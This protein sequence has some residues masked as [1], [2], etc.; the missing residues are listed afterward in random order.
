MEKSLFVAKRV[1]VRLGVA[2][3]FC[4]TWYFAGGQ[5][6]PPAVP[7]VFI[8][9]LFLAAA[10]FSYLRHDG[11]L[12]LNRRNTP[13]PRSDRMESAFRGAFK[14]QPHEERLLDTTPNTAPA[15]MRLAVLSNVLAGVLSI[16]LS[17]LL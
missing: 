13:N 15:D 12:F 10:W 8:G 1:A 6:E 3:V 11:L 2:A 9:A 14:P 16:A 7:L 5:A 4:A 17:F